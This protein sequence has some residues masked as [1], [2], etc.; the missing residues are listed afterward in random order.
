MNQNWS[1]KIFKFVPR[2]IIRHKRMAPSI[3]DIGNHEEH[4]SR[5]TN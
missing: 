5:S 3:K 2:D 4:V 1:I